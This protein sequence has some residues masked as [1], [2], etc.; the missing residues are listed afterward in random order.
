MSD[1]GTNEAGAGWIMEEAVA[2]AVVVVPLVSST[3]LYVNPYVQKRG[4]TAD[5][6][7]RHTTRS[8]LRC[9]DGGSRRW[10]TYYCSVGD[11][12][13]NPVCAGANCIHGTRVLVGKRVEIILR[14]LEMLVHCRHSSHGLLLARGVVDKHG[15]LSHSRDEAIACCCHEL[16]RGRVFTHGAIVVVLKIDETAVNDGMGSLLLLLGLLKLWP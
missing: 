8:H 4:R 9:H 12:V 16:M 1:S 14:L 6:R 3:G 5:I 7:P 2:V 10:L 13:I 15:L 11:T